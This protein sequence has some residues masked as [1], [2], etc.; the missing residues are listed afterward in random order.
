MLFLT[1]NRNI[2]PLTAKLYQRKAAILLMCVHWSQV[3]LTNHIQNSG[4][5]GTFSSQKTTENLKGFQ[6]LGKQWQV[7][8]LLFE[9]LCKSWVLRALSETP[10]TNYQTIVLDICQNVFKSMDKSMDKWVIDAPQNFGVLLLTD[11]SLS[12]SN[13]QRVISCL[14]INYPFMSLIIDHWL[15]M[16]GIENNVKTVDFL[17]DIHVIRGLSWKCHSSW[18]PFD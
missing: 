8:K 14:L 4:F 5:S 13:T 11:Y 16:F 2:S 18:T 17:H 7:A 1:T 3:V 10:F 9:V 15:V 6:K 12:T